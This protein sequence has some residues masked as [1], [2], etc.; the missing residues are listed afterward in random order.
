M[1]TIIVPTDFSKDALHAA[2]YALCLSSA[3]QVDLTLCHAFEVPV[4]MAM[5]PVEA[6]PLTDQKSVLKDTTE[7]LSSLAKKL[8]ILIESDST[9]HTYHP[10]ISYHS[11]Q[12][13]LLHVINSQLKTHA[14]NLVVMG[15]HGA[16]A[17]SRFFMGSESHYVIAKAYYPVI[18]I[19]KNVVFKQ[20]RKIAFATDLGDKD[21]RVIHSLAGFAKYFNAEILLFNICENQIDAKQHIKKVNAFLEDIVNKIDYD[22]IYYHHAEDA[23]VDK[24]LKWI[25]N[26]SEIDLMVM[27]H[28]KSNWV[29]QLFTGSHTQ[30]L[31]TEI[32]IPLMVIPDNTYSVF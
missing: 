16:G 13:S 2:E 26:N 4:N 19:P 20:I 30:E 3:M 6:W 8:S 21:I 17:L 7:G 11:E 28:H 12:G 23:E 29:A 18:L 27:V 9:D 5:F 1:K 22:H 25:A 15:L 10:K 31:A 24:G 32:K 14:V